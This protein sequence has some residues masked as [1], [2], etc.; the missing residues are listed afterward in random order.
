LLRSFDKLRTGYE[1]KQRKATLFQM[2]RW[3]KEALRW[4]RTASITCMAL[5]F[6]L[7]VLFY[8]FSIVSFFCLFINFINRVTA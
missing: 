7:A 3:N 1:K 8:S 6:H 2:L 4:V 5:E